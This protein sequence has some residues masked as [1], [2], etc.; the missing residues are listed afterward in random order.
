MRDDTQDLCAPYT[1]AAKYL[2]L[3]EPA[4]FLLYS[5]PTRLLDVLANNDPCNQRNQQPGFGQKLVELA[6]SNRMA[7]VNRSGSTIRDY[8]LRI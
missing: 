3:S 1:L 7:A 5:P 8:V 6:S 4:S 2:G